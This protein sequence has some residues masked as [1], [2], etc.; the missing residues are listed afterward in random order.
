[1]MVDD[2]PHG[3]LLVASRTCQPRLI[4]NDST[5]ANTYLCLHFGIVHNG[6]EEEAV[7]VEGQHLHLFLLTIL[8]LSHTGFQIIQCQI[9][10]LLFQATK[11]HCRGQQTMKTSNFERNHCA[12]EKQSEGVVNLSVS[13]TYRPVGFKSRT[14]G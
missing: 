13:Y 8:Y 1:M 7:S 4:E 14:C 11:I 10:D 2:A 12:E 9:T 3:S 5:Q 6:W